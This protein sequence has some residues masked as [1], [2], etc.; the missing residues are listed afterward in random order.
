MPHRDRLDALRG[1]FDRA[2]P[3]WAARS[4]Q[5]GLAEA[6]IAP[7]GLRAGGRV[8]DLGAGTGHLLPVL[9]NAVGG[10]GTICALDLSMK[11][12]KYAASAASA[13]A[14]LTCGSA[15]AL[16][17]WD[18][19]WDAAICMGIYPHFADRASALAEIHRVLRPGGKMAILH[20]IGREQLNALHRQ[21]GGVIADDLL[22]DSQEVA[23]SL[24]AAGFRVTEVADRAESYR[25]IGI[26]GD[27]EG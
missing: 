8:L 10:A 23:Q 12:L 11:M 27:T 26:K 20:M 19:F 6:L 17:L 3:T 13:N 21:A 14:F 25:A 2:A 16:P 15:E 4:F 7:L 5:A 9:R 18:D 24:E 22:P 1:F